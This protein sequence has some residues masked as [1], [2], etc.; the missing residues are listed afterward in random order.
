[1]FT[2]PREAL[3]TVRA[4]ARRCQ[5]GRPSGLAPPV[6]IAADGTTI[7]LTVAFPEAAVALAIPAADNP[8]GIASL[9]VPMALV[10]AVEGADSDPVGLHPSEKGAKAGAA[11]EA[12]AVTA[13]WTDRGLP[14]ERTFDPVRPEERPDPPPLPASW[15]TVPETVLEALHEAGRIAARDTGGRFAFHRVQVRRDRIVATDSRQVLVQA[16]FAL[17][18]PA[19]ASLLVP[20]IPVFGSKE[21]RR[22]TASVPVQLGVTATHLAVRAGP[23]TV[24]L[25][26]DATGKYPDVD[27]VFPKGHHP[28]VAT[29]SESDAAHL[30]DALP[31]LPGHADENAPVTLDLDARRVARGVA[32]GVAV[33]AKG[34]DDPAATEFTLAGSAADGPP[35]RYALDRRSLVRALSLGFRI[36]R[37]AAADRPYVSI[38]GDRT[39][40]AAGLHPSAALPPATNRSPT[41]G[42]APVVPVRPHCSS[43]ENPMKSLNGPR[44]AGRT[45]PVPTD[46]LDLPAEAESLRLA[47]VDVVQKAA[48]LVAALKHQRKEKK[49]LTQVWSSLKSLNLGS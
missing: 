23:W 17:P 4:V 32:G 39:W 24:W 44:P 2:L 46:D 3:R 18:V 29:I 25:Q 31:T 21:F 9:V 14:R 5:P 49:A 41:A 42:I 15:T 45:E 47:L 16:G 6:R 10:E 38:D 7:T 22:R 35:V 48:R 36:F 27:D 20:A 40:L 26:R 37:F 11:K 19:K 30:L 34:D 28:A 33:R 8:G 12:S 13:R 43:P 1:M